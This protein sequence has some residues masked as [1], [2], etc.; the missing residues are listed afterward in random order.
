MNIVY[1]RLIV[2]ALST[3]AGLMPAAW[4]GFAAYDAVA[5]TITISIQGLATMIAVGLTATASVFAR[6]GT[7]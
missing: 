1:I 5:G 6:W 4:A 2:Y 7:K 3:L